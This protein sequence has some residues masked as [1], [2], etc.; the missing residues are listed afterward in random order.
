MLQIITS[1]DLLPFG[2]VMAVYEEGNR[3]NGAERYPHL[4]KNR[5]ILEA[6]QD[7]YNY[8]RTF[9]QQKDSFYSLWIVNNE[10]VSALRV[11]DY[12]DGWLISALETKPEKRERGYATALLLE[13]VSY[14]LRHDKTPIYSHV[15]NANLPSI[16]VH[17]KVGFVKYLPYSRYLDGTVLHNSST[18]RYNSKPPA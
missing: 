16:A 8:L 10:I 14:L 3:E 12:E 2:E 11:E 7:F 13:T 1:L 17:E 9:F 15:S 4:S 5:Q 18:Y 6:E